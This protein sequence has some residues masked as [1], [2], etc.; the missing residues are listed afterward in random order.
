MEQPDSESHKPIWERE[1]YR[2]ETQ[3]DQHPPPSADPYNPVFSQPDAQKVT[4]QTYYNRVQTI[5]KQ[6]P[7]YHTGPWVTAVSILVAVFDFSYFIFTLFVLYT[8]TKVSSATSVLSQTEEAGSTPSRWTSPLHLNA[9]MVNLVFI[10]QIGVFIGVVAW[11]WWFH[12]V[13]IYLEEHDDPVPI[14]RYSLIM[15]TVSIP[16]LLLAIYTQLTRG[17]GD[18]PGFIK[19]LT[20][21]FGMALV[22][23]LVAYTVAIV[24]LLQKTKEAK[25]HIDTDGR[26]RT[27]TSRPDTQNLHHD[28]AAFENPDKE[29]DN[30]RE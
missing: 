29:H 18:T 7:D 5:E 3:T 15:L 27:L 25:Q 24:G 23:W 28:S 17:T 9:D 4:Y 11:T 12:K 1:E 2:P 13:K 16:A 10:L 20:I 6:K 26:H 14:F 21:A 19:T 8:I 22:G 30:Y